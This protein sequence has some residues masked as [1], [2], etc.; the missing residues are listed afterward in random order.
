V[1][2]LFVALVLLLMSFLSALAPLEGLRGLAMGAG[3]Y[4]WVPDLVLALA[5]VAAFARLT[6]L[7]RRLLFPRRGVRL[8]AGGIALYA[9]GA[10]LATGLAVSALRLLPPEAGGPGAAELAARAVPLPIFLAAQL[11]LVL[12]A[13]RAMTN[14]VPP[15]EFAAD[16]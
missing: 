3:V 13:F 2:R 9:L 4:R 10:A 11:L 8:L 16:F 5:L 7:H 12:G 14:L 1:K 15:D 6:Q